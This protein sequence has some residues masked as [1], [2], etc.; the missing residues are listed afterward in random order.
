M[1]ADAPTDFASR[2]R[3]AVADR[4]RLCV[5]IDPH[6]G[7]LDAWGLTDDV[8]GLRRFAEIAVAAL[9]PVAASIKPQVALFE[10]FGS[11]GF[12]VL[13][14]TIAGIGAGGSLVVA[15]AKRGDIGSTMDAYA[16]AWLRDGSPLCSDSVTVSPYLGFGSLDPAVRAAQDSGRGVFVLARTSN[17]EGAALQTAHADGSSVAQA[18]VDAAA[19]T[20][21]TGPSAV[22]L[23]VGATRAHGLD[24]GAVGGPILAPGVGAQGGT[25]ADV[26]AI[27][28]GVHEWVLPAVSREI[29]RHGPDR[30]ALSD[31]VARMRDD[32]ES[33]LRG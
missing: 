20:N 29:L 31:A 12:A 18:I 2:H 17:P 24:L 15:D 23:V 21:R 30:T 25:A 22:G 16:S 8:D 26:A 28:A 5:G 6:P 14:Q 4:G 19:E 27:F 33:H 10:R 1:S 11:A 3:A 9:A 32:I 13:E 7:L